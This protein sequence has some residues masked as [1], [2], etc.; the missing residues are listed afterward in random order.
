MDAVAHEIS[1][2]AAIVLALVGVYFLV[3]ILVLVFI[4][5]VDLVAGRPGALADLAEQA[6]YLLITLALAANA[7]AIGRAFAG[8]AQANKDALLSGDITRLSALIAPATRL[9]TGLAANLAI[10]FTLMAVVYIALKGQLANLASSSEGLARSIL[11]VATALVVLGF[12]I[13]AIL[14]GRSL[15]LH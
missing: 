4:S 5:Q 15:L 3:R 8:L 2:F 10:A 6:I 9:V 11:Q 7:Q 13:L 12:G 14:I 1:A